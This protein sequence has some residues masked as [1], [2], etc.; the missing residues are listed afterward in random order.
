[1]SAIFIQKCAFHD[2]EEM[3]IGGMIWATIGFFIFAA[4][5]YYFYRN[6]SYLQFHGIISLVMFSMLAGSII[7]SIVVVLLVT[8]KLAVR[9]TLFLL[10]SSLF[11]FTRIASFFIQI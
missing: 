11:L 4:I 8:E 9:G 1:V 2:A 7:S 10:G 6:P 5:P 3:S